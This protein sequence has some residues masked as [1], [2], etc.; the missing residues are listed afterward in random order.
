[1]KVPHGGD[2]WAVARRLGCDPKDILDFSASVSPLGPSSKALK[3]IKE[4]LDLLPAYPDPCAVSFVRALRKYLSVEKKYLAVGNG[5]IELIYLLAQILK[6]RRALIV[7]PAFG[8]YAKSLRLVGCEVESFHCRE[9]GDF[10]LL[11]DELTQRIT[12]STDLD[13]LYMANPA[14]PTGKLT[15]RANIERILKVCEERDITFVVDEAFCDFTPDDSVLPLVAQSKSLVVLRSMTK[16]FSLAGLRLGAIIAPEG[17]IMEVIE[18]R[19]PWSI[20]SLA[21]AS[22]LASLEDAV[23]IEE[24]R[25]WFKEESAFMYE[26]LSKIE[27]LKV[28]PSSANFFMLKTLGDGLSVSDLREKLKAEKILIRPLAEFLGLGERFFRVAV[29]KRADNIKLIERMKIILKES[30]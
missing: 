11:Y 9:A 24:V 3:S 4:S 19:V 14:N 29:R 10:K 8:E 26:E 7:E 5:S 27:G 6:P 18:R 12:N 28:F 22:G 2:I 23:H 13:I 16:F 17:I 21:L 30:P 15:S 20:N 25:E 1:M